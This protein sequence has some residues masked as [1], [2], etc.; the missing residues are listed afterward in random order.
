MLYVVYFLW[1]QNSTPVGRLLYDP[2]CFVNRKSAC[3]ISSCLVQGKCWKKMQWAVIFITGYIPCEL[4]LGAL[5]DFS[6][7][8]SRVVTGQLHG[9][10][11]AAVMKPSFFVQSF[12]PH[13]RH[14]GLAQGE[15]YTWGCHIFHCKR[16]KGWY[17]QHW[18]QHEARLSSF[19]MWQLPAVLQAM[20][21]R[22]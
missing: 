7:S 11:I 13:P 14:I 18:K 8:C 21:N 17:V 6:T 16:C 9:R 19:V 3:D 5:W 2:R 20:N 12:A 22:S 10:P 4:T 15:K 1:F